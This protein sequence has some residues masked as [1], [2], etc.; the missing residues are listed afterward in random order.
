MSTPYGEGVP[1]H[2]R[3]LTVQGHGQPLVG[4]VSCGAH[5]KNAYHSRKDAKV[6]VKIM[7]RKNPTV[8]AYPCDV[9]D[10]KWHVGSSHRLKDAQHNKRT[11]GSGETTDGEVAA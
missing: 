2:T 1:P 3:R 7:R 10:G 9:L 11:A 4:Y 5:G 6:V 8:E